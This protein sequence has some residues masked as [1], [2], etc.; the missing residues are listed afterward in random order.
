CFHLAAG[1][2]PIQG[3]LCAPAQEGFRVGRRRRQR[4]R[5]PVRRSGN[6]GAEEGYQCRV[7]GVFDGTFAGTSGN[8]RSCLLPREV[9]GRGGRNRRDTGEHSEDALVLCAQETGRAAEGSRCR[10]RL[11]MMALSKKML[12]QEPSEIEALLPWHAAGT[13]NARDAR[14]VEE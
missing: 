13:L 3:P 1:N 12:E 10:A 14:R 11:A 7:A 8:R 4:D 6:G 9:R 2:H 5:G